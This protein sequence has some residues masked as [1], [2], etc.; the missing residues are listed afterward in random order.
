MSWEQFLAIKEEAV[1]YV[2]QERTEPPLAC[3]FDGQPLLETPNGQGLYCSL[4][5][6]VWPLQ[7]RII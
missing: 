2:V 7:P 1:S 5:N 6:Y 4:G 3:P